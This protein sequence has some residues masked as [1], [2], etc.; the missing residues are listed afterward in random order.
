MLLTRNR[1]WGNIIGGNERSGYKELKKALIGPAR[2]NWYKFHELNLIYPFTKEWDKRN[3]LKEK[4]QERRMRIFMRG[5]KIGSKKGGT[6]IT[7]M[8]IFEM[9]NKKKIN[10][11]VAAQ[12]LQEEAAK[13]GFTDDSLGLT[14]DA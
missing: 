10:D 11:P 5:V 8:S 1:I 13:A 6:Q 4:H 7:T 3:E 9:Q 12:K 14:S 2:L